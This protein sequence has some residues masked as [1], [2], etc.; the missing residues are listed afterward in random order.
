MFLL[1]Q[2]MQQT[3]TKN[4]TDAND[5]YASVDFLCLGFARAPKLNEIS[6]SEAVHVCFGYPADAL[7]RLGTRVDSLSQSQ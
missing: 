4:P 2:L 7:E 3:A 6:N 5:S 1:N